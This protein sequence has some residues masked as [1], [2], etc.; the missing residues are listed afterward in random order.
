MAKK[1]G[2]ILVE[3]G[4]ITQ[5]QILTA[6]KKQKKEGGR[7]GSILVELGYISD[8]DLISVLSEQFGVPAVDLG[9]IEVDEKVLKLIP[10]HIAERLNVFPLKREGKILHL[11]MANP[12]DI[13]T[14]EDI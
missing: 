13:Y 8:D 5:K 2:E 3:K 4:L 1:L 11:A 12:A 7:L 9:N 10:Q 14:V 6:L